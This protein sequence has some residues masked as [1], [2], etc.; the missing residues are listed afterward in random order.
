[1]DKQEKNFIQAT[2]RWLQRVAD[3]KQAESHD[4]TK[5]DFGVNLSWWNDG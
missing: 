5:S 4:I 3:R 2:I 1:M